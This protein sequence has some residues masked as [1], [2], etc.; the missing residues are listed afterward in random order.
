[1]PDHIW[2][3]LA[4]GLLAFLLFAPAATAAEPGRKV[5]VAAFG[6]FGDQSVFESEAKGAA[7]IV[8]KRFS[9]G[10]VV[11]RA[12]TKR[13]SDATLGTLAATLDSVA[14]KMDAENDVL[15]VIL[16]SHGS[17][18]GLVVKAGAREETL[19]PW[20]LAATLRYTG[21]RHRLVIISAC[22]SGIFLPLA[23][24]DTMVI[25]AADADHPSFGC[26][27]GAQWTYFGDAFFNTAMRRAA[28]LRDAFNQAREIVRKRE[29]QNGFD[30]S[31]PQIAGGENIEN[32][33]Q[34]AAP[35]APAPVAASRPG[36]TPEN[37]AAGVSTQNCSPK[38]AGAAGSRRD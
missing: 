1:M 34:A 17:R 4:A 19:S 10:A 16:T 15:L 2:K 20:L 32:L 33:L 28:N 27:D 11:V 24:A 7:G 25:T 38:C 18:A 36:G 30:P 22:Y 29:L 31:N 3:L 21:V 14:K 35:A 5:A 12:N 13:R 6:L 37:A 8:A 26:R 9:A 23:D